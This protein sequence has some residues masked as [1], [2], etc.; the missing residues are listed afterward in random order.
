MR[1]AVLIIGL[2]I[3]AAVTFQACTVYGLSGI[4]EGLG[5]QESADRVSASA[6]GI[7]TGLLIMV[8]AGFV[9]PFP[10]VAAAIFVLAGLLGISV[11]NT[12]DFSDQAVWGV[13]A[14]GLAVM[15]YF[16][17]RSKRREDEVRAQERAALAAL[18]GGAAAQGATA[19][20]A[21]PESGRFKALM[22]DRDSGKISLEEYRRRA[23]A[24]LDGR[25]DL[26]RTKV[27]PDCAETVKADAKICRFCRHDFANESE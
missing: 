23:D 8:G 3:G 21:V 25:D 5:S 4:G 19:A 1:I 15:A 26:E 2:V 6:A 17:S 7:L 9:M 12:S 27:C 22:D 20:P 18:R 24:V 16:G 14:F 11:S 13:V 10:R